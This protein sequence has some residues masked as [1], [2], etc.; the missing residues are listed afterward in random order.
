M[1]WVS[2]CTKHGWIE[3]IAHLNIS[4]EL[5]QR[6]HVNKNPNAEFAI[7]EG[8]AAINR[9]GSKTLLS[10]QDYNNYCSKYQ[11]EDQISRILKP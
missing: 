3:C 7:K 4:L 2:W 11:S 6:Y 8:H 9:N 1:F 5:G 10:D